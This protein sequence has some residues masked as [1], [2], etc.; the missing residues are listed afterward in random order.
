MYVFEP[1]YIVMVHCVC[2]M[3]SGYTVHNETEYIYRSTCMFAVC[4]P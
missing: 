1:V 2:I 4:V 3:S